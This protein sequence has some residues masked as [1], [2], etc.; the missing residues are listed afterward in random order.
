MGFLPTFGRAA[1]QQDDPRAGSQ[2]AGAVA[3]AMG[4]LKGWR[5]SFYESNVLEEIKAQIT[6][7]KQSANLARASEADLAALK[8]G[9]AHWV[10]AGAVVGVVW[11]AVDALTAYRRENGLLMFA[12]FGRSVAGAGAIGTGLA[13][14]YYSKNMTVVLWCTR[15]NIVTGILI[16]AAGYAIE[17]L[18]EKEWAEWLQAEPFR[19]SGSKVQP[20][21]TE[22]L[23]LSSL[24]NA[25]ADME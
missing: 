6:V 10:A 14:A 3:H 18:K 16:A 9:A 1:N 17:K 12:Y 11:D 13:T 4:T 8:I 19:N 21:R 5:A 24:A 7:H 15:I 20:H 2:A 23:M 22:A 25:I